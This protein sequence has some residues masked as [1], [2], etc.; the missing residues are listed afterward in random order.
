MA[1]NT[2]EHISF[3]LSHQTTGA[4]EISNFLLTYA[5]VSEIK[6]TMNFC[7]QL[8]A[9]TSLPLETTQVPPT[10]GNQ[11]PGQP[12]NVAMHDS[13]TALTTHRGPVTSSETLIT[14]DVFWQEQRVA[15]AQEDQAWLSDYNF[16][17]NNIYNYE[18]STQ[19]EDQALLSDHNFYW[20]YIDNNEQPMEE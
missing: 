10:E 14:S 19:Q 20:D 18:Q 3:V 9:N 16:Y 7:F 13:L 8:V 12:V 6:N 2:E 15:E 11:D 17:R 5:M 4:N 1:E